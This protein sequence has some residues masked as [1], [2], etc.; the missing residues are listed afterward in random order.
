ML[1]SL[2]TVLIFCAGAILS[3]MAN[4]QSDPMRVAVANLTQDVNALAQQMKAL[5]L[6]M[7][8]LRRENAE[9]R[10][11]RSGQQTQSQLSNLSSAIEVLRREYRAADAVQKKEIINE[12]SRQIDALGRQTEEAIQSVANAVDAQPNVSTPVRFSDDY[13]KSG[14]TYT[15]R[16]GDTLSQIAREHKSTVKHIQ[17]ANKIVNPA[18]D[19]M[20]GQT[21]FIPI[22]E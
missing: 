10:V 15:V 9:L 19:L 8:Q 21:I 12:V 14:L 6:E 4:G 5:R 16:S 22:Q 18:K 3:P 13:P 17:N 7:E 2:F 1:K 20:V 11:D